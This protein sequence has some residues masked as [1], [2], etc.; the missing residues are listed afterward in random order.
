MTPT[1]PPRISVVIPCY[2]YAHYVGAAIESALAQDY[3]HIEVVVVN[4]GSTDDSLQ[5]IQRYAP[6]VK[7]VD[8]PN[9]GSIAAYNRGFAESSG[10][11]VIFLDADDLLEPG[12]LLQVGAR[13]HPSC[14]K[15]QFDLKI[16]DGAGADTGRRFCNFATGYGSAQA[17][18]AF[19]RTGTYRWPVTSGNAYSRWFLDLM[20]PLDIEHGP[21]GLLNTVAPV[22]GDVTVLPQVL[23]AYR[24]HGANMWSSDGTDSSRLPFRIHTR[25]REVAFMQEHAAR[26][27]VHVP[28]GNVLD[29]ELPF[30]NYRLMALKLGLAYRDQEQDTPWRLVWR[31]WRLVSGETLSLKH[32]IGHIGWFAALALAPRRAAE[33]LIRLRFN[34]TAVIQS[35][36]RSI[37]LS[38]ARS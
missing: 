27:G 19:L 33:A 14:A 21:D 4:D 12:A 5:V 8:Q 16:I 7:I 36:R 23:G 34:R 20:F 38:L 24:V 30:L 31:A 37:G 10:D 26:R 32:R 29:R 1:T 3:A 18:S 9:Q 15:L 28:A 13:W 35:L 11:V 2:N 25:Q 17:R 6:R 22:Y